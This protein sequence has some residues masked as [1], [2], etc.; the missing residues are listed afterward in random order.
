MFG[1]REM[2]SV[3]IGFV[4]GMACPAGVVGMVFLKQYGPAEMCIFLSMFFTVTTLTMGLLAMA[5]GM[6]TKSCVSSKALGRSIYYASCILS[7][8]LGALWIILN[9]THRL[10]S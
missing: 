3:L 10:D 8:F 2:G 4:Q 5:Y 6:L 9:A 7:L 1:S